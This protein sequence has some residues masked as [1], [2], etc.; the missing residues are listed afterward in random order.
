MNEYVPFDPYDKFYSTVDEIKE[1]TD[2][3][4]YEEMDIFTFFMDNYAKAIDNFNRRDSRKLT[5]KFLLTYASY[6]SL[7]KL[8]NRLN[9]YCTKKRTNREPI[10]SSKVP[11]DLNTLKEDFPL[12]DMTN[13]TRCDSIIIKHYCYMLLSYIR[14][15]ANYII[16]NINDRISMISAEDYI[17]H[18]EFLDNLDIY[19]QPFIDQLKLYHEKYDTGKTIEEDTPNIDFEPLLL[20]YSNM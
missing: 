19:K 14:V 16:R 5:F 8:H 10:L 12:I 1:M 11:L 17:E 18:A 15:Y 20:F 9:E 6:F 4:R 3:Q 2:E 7:M 13:H